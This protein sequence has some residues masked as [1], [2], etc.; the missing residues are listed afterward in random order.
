MKIIF[1]GNIKQLK[2]DVLFVSIGPKNK[3]EKM[4]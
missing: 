1:K 2:D 4:Q 3:D